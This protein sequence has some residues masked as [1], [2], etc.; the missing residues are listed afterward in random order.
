MSW[1]FVGQG[2]G[3]GS[4]SGGLCEVLWKE[5]HVPYPQKQPGTPSPERPCT[6][7][8]TCHRHRGPAHHLSWFPVAAIADDRSG[9]LKPAEVYSLAVLEATSP[10]SGL[11]AGPCHPPNTSGGGPRFASS[12]FWKPR[13]C[14]VVAASRRWRPPPPPCGCPHRC[15][16]VSSF[17]E[18]QVI[19]H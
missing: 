5:P 13:P 17:R 19:V 4:H 3:G 16:C 10:K 7:P 15:L 11:G 6:L 18:G 9:W 8:S 1:A 14:G 2:L 12:G